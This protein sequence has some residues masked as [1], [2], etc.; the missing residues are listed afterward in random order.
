[1]NFNKAPLLLLRRL[2]LVINTFGIHELLVITM[3][4]DITIYHNEDDVSILN[5]GQAVGDDK[6]SPTHHELA[7]SLL[8]Q[9]FCSG[10]DGGSRLIQD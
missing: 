1:M 6:A 7:E 5:S 3:L 2:H 9:D 10:I 4:D 8:N